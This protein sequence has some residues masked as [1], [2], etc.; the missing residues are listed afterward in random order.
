M[1]AQLRSLRLAGLAQVSLAS[2]RLKPLAPGSA[3]ASGVALTGVACIY[4][5][6]KIVLLVHFLG[7]RL[8]CLLAGCL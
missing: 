2:G 7:F 3:F 5:H 8:R 6:L 4:V 1:A